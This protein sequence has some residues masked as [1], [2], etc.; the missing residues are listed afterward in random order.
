MITRSLRFNRRAFA[1]AADAAEYQSFKQDILY[2]PHRPVSFSGKT[3]T[4]FENKEL[5]LRKNMPFEIKDQLIKNTLG[6]FGAY[7]GTFIFPY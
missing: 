4:V 6:V 7:A 1:A 2:K 3:M 5:S